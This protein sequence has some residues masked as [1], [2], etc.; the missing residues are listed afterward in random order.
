MKKFSI[1]MMV[2]MVSGCAYPVYPYRYSP[3]ISYGPYPTAAPYVYSY[4][5]PGYLTPYY[6]PNPAWWY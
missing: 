4:Y 1:L 3:Y 2:A 5:Y 6:C